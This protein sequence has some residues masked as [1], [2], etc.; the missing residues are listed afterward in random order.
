MHGR[1]G[2]TEEGPSCW[3]S[4]ARES[5]AAVLTHCC[6]KSAH[7]FPCQM[8]CCLPDSCRNPHPHL[9]AWW[10]E[11]TST[12]LKHHRGF[13]SSREKLIKPFEGPFADEITD[14]RTP[15]TKPNRTAICRTVK[16]WA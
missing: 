10:E 12:L 15:V 4:E 13:F 1:N 16:T 14:L 5:P 2:T 3:L 11:E 8:I 9:I 6:R 7:V